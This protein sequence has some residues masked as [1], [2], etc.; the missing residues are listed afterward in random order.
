MNKRNNLNWFRVM[1]S[2]F[3]RRKE[4]LFRRF[5]YLC[6][7]LKLIKAQEQEYFSKRHDKRISIVTG[8]G[9]ILPLFSRRNSR[10]DHRIYIPAVQFRQ[11][12]FSGN[13]NSWI[14]GHNIIVLM[15]NFSSRDVKIFSN[16]WALVERGKYQ[17]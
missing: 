10:C 17:G 2:D 16:A 14:E 11:F 4:L 9:A 6:V 5:W 3:L 7:S 13:I 12:F 1:L 8:V 15:Q